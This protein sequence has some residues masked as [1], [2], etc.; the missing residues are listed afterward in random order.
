[1][2]CYLLQSV[3]WA[4][5]FTPFL[6]DL[7]DTLTVATTALLATAAW[8]LTAVAADRMRAAGNRVPFETL[9]RRV[10]YGRGPRRAESPATNPGMPGCPNSPGSPPVCTNTVVSPAAISPRRAAAISPAIAR[11]V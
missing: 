1:M 6:L 2:T 11:P 4:A 5:V 8:A 10:T 9:V 7:S 3:A